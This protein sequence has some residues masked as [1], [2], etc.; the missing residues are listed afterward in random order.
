MSSETKPLLSADVEPLPKAVRAALVIA[1]I[2]L[3]MHLLIGGAELLNAFRTS[4][5]DGLERF[6]PWLVTTDLLVSSLRI[7]N[8]WLLEDVFGWSVHLTAPS[9]FIMMYAI[10]C[11]V[12]AGLYLNPQWFI[13][14]TMGM[15][16]AKRKT[17]PCSEASSERP[18]V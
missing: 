4:L 7:L 6:T 1:R 18:A 12:M 15:L 11:H 17:R 13:L 3:P 16:I 2:A 10:R 9:I 8:N 5:C 14:L